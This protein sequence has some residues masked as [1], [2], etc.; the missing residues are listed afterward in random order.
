MTTRILTQHHIPPLHLNDQ[1]QQFIQFNTNTLPL[2]LY[3]NPNI[4]HNLIQVKCSSSLPP[5]TRRQQLT[6]IECETKYM[7]TINIIMS[8]NNIN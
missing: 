3:P 5:Q 2:I 4:S 8:C 1:H 6:H 7:Y